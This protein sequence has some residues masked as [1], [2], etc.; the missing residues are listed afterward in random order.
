MRFLLAKET[1]SHGSIWLRFQLTGF[2]WIGAALSG[3]PTSGRAQNAAAPAVAACD[4][5]LQK[6]ALPGTNGYRNLGDRCEG[7]H[8]QQVGGHGPLRLIAIVRADKA[9]LTNAR[10]LR[11]SWPEAGADSITLEARST[12]P[13]VIYSMTMVRPGH[14][15]AYEW[16]MRKSQTEGLTPL[17]FAFLA[18]ARQPGVP[19]A[20]LVHL[21]LEVSDSSGQE[22][23]GDYNIVVIP[24]RRLQ[25]VLVS[26]G[27][28]GPNRAVTRWIYKDRSLGNRVYQ[29]DAPIIMSLPRAEAGLL[30]VTLNA[31]S[32]GGVWLPL[33]FIVRSP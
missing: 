26:V 1:S 14:H 15:G 12:R 6:L 10:K 13:H 21:P 17:D 33:S 11:I 16:L 19:E 9:K 18:W 27:E 24:D 22:P 32:T 4:S 30:R 23:G 20:E 5:T 31:K 3:L 8:A 2:L 28:L 29:R 25:E 7:L